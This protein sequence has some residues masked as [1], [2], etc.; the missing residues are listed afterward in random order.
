MGS[1]SFTHTF[2]HASL[3]IWDAWDSF[4][5]SVAEQAAGQDSH[6]DSCSERQVQAYDFRV[7]CYFL[8]RHPQRHCRRS[9]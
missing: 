2:Y 7:L 3:G 4:E 8:D 5:E 6:R 1:T 9:H